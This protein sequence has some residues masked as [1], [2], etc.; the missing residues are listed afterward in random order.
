M[1]ADEREAIHLRFEEVEILQR[2]RSRGIGVRALVG[3]AWGFAAR[4][5]ADEATAVQAARDAVEVARAA[6]QV[7]EHRVSLVEEEPGRGQWANP[8]A[9]DP[10]AV[11]LE[12]K[13]ADLLAATTAL[14]GSTAE[15]ARVQSAEASMLWQRRRSHFVST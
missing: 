10:F 1:A 12:R 9:E 14:R 6:A 2:G 13:I 15:G 5:G 7:S 4:P 8:V 3:G 11:P